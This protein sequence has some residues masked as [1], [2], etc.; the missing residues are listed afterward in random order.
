[1]TVQILAVNPSLQIESHIMEE[2][3]QAISHKMGHLYML[4]HQSVLHDRVEVKEQQPHL[5]AKKMRRE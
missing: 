4:A 3:Y 1:M 2:S 5:H